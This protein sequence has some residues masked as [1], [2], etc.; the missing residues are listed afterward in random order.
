MEEEQKKVPIPFKITVLYTYLVIVAI[1]SLYVAGTT[2][3]SIVLIEIVYQLFGVF[4]NLYGFLYASDYFLLVFL[5][6]LCWIFYSYGISVILMIIMIKL[7]NGF[8]TTITNFSEKFSYEKKKEF[9]EIYCSENANGKIVLKLVILLSNTGFFWV[10]VELI[11]G[12]PLSLS[13][14]VFYYSFLI[15]TPH[16]IEIWMRCI[17]MVFSSEPI[18]RNKDTKLKI[19]ESEKGSLFLIKN[20]LDPAQLLDFSG[21]HTFLSHEESKERRISFF[22]FFIV[23]L[24]LLSFMVKGYQVFFYFDSHSSQNIFE[25]KGTNKI[26]QMLPSIF[27]FL[28]SPILIVFHFGHSWRVFI[29]S[30]LAQTKNKEEQDSNLKLQRYKDY[31][32][33]SLAFKAIPILYLLLSLSFLCLAAVIGWVWQSPN[34]KYLGNYVDNIYNTNNYSNTPLPSQFCSMNSK[35]LDIL[36]ISSLPSLL[37]FYPRGKNYMESLTQSQKNNIKVFLRMVF[38]DKSGDILFNR[39]SLTQWG[40]NVQIPIN[41][42]QS[43]KRSVTVR[44]YCGYRSPFDWAMYTELFI[45]KSF[46]AFF[47]SIIPGY[48]MALGFLKDFLFN[49]QD[50]IHSFSDLTSTASKI[51][52]I[53]YL[54][55]LNNPVDLIVGQGIG[56][57]FSKYIS[58]KSGMKTPA[59]AFDS[60]P[61]FGSLIDD[62]KNTT[63]DS[64]V[65]VFSTGLFGETEEQLNM[66]FQR[67][68]PSTSWTAP[69]SLFSF[70]NTVAQCSHSKE[71]HSFC[72]NEVEDFNY[73]LEQYQRE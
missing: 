69:S 20:F 44:V 72:Y 15:I 67:V 71:Y 29:V 30:S 32:T 40:I 53:E 2:F 33:L 11:K 64:I 65:N 39:S 60:L 55:Y 57:Y 34:K 14:F 45:Q 19:D 63:S 1:F 23:I 17:N 28:L 66:N 46:S 31:G 62:M 18:N 42:I 16:L 21:V 4:V 26:F 49:V 43:Q 5:Q 13:P 35:G 25:F 22:H 70:C 56:G 48:S 38:K 58:A 54:S 59:F 24:I 9:M 37:Y 27:Y 10:L 50:L 47:E 52:N 68:G 73:L 3:V 12:K 6:Q 8:F 61:F 36:E 7:Y 41:D 51:A